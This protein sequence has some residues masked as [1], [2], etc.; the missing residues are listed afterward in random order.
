[1]TH[2]EKILYKTSLK[3]WT[4]DKIHQRA[5]QAEHAGKNAQDAANNEEKSSAGDKYETGRAM[6]QLETN[7]HNMLLAGIRKEISQLQA[8]DISRIYDSVVPG[9]FVRCDEVSFFITAGLGKHVINGL[10]IIFMSPAAPLLKEILHKKA[11]DTFT[12]QGREQKI[13][14]IF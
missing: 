7:M 3:Q 14:E 9:S 1:M 8:L 10:T 11:N 13:L 4:M 2:R 6:A 5:R 12:F